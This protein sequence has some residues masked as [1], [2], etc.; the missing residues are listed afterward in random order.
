MARQ[1]GL[2]RLTPQQ[3]VLAEVNMNLA[4]NIAWKYHRST[5]IEY[6]ILEG[7]AFE[8]LCQAAGK[9]DPEL[10]NDDTGRPMKFSSLAVPYIRGSILHYI[11][12]RTYSIRLTHK[13]RETWV[14][15]RK[16]LVQ[17]LGDLEISERLGVSLEEW[18]DTKSACSGPPLELKDQATPT[19]ALE[20][21]EVDH[22]TPFREQAAEMIG[23]MSEACRQRLSKY[24]L[25][26]SLDPPALVVQHVRDLLG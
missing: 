14:K 19:E 12:D 5:N 22:L 20:P 25:S 6:L 11:R 13:M 21:D 2:V 9:Y 7:A 8:G 24:L 15:G 26:R 16:M 17:G 1:R 3:Q 4:R 18:Q 23:N 10:I